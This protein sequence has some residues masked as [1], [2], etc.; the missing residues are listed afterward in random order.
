VK[1]RAALLAA[2]LNERATVTENGKRRQA[3]RREAVIAKLVNISVSAVLRP[4]RY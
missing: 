3:T 1:N 4:P 2:A